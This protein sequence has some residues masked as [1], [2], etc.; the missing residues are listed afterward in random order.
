MAEAFI[1]E[2]RMFGGNYAPYHWS[3]CSGTLL[4]VAQNTALFSLLG[5]AYGGDGRTSFALPDTRGRAPVHYGAGPGLTPVALGARYG[6]ETVTLTVDQIPSHL[7]PI[8]ATTNGGTTSN[9][10]G[11]V[12]ADTQTQ[13]INVYTPPTDPNRVRE[14][15]ESA[16]ESQGGGQAHTNMMPF[17][18]VNFIICLQ[19][20]FPS[21]N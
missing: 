15:H 19:G 20:T 1:G 9:P 5:S 7:H 2:I 8:Q 12:P 13:S 3:Y 11:R 16:V 6:G 21:R 17:L 14:F 4:A 10:I 18:A